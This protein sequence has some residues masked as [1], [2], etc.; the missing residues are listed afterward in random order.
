MSGKLEEA[1]PVAIFD[2]DGTIT[3]KSTTVPFL[4]FVFGVSFLA[5]LSCQLHSLLLYYCRIIDI[6]ELNQII[7]QSFFKNLSRDYLFHQ[8]QNF[9]EKI[10]PSLI[11]ESA[12]QRIKWHK[13][14]GHYCILATSAYDLY[15]E[16]WSK[17]NCFNDLVST[18]IAFDE[19]WQATGTLDGK[20]CY[21]KEKLQRVLELIGDKPR[22]VYAYGDSAGDKAILDY[23][24]YPYYKYFK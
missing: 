11:R 8:G 15:T 9:S 4:R 1:Q 23:A 18:K 2:F 22:I 24:T 6:D 17:T 5:R 21:G 19:R 3:R 20:S 16:H 10:L 7:V 13:S 12:F 14:Q